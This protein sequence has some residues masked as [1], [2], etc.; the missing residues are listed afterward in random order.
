LRG[1]TASSRT[2][3]ALRRAGPRSGLDRGESGFR[4]TG[5]CPSAGG[6]AVPELSKTGLHSSPRRQVAVAP[7]GL[8]GPSVGFTPPALRL[9]GQPCGCPDSIR[10]N[11]GLGPSMDL[12][13]RAAWRLSGSA[14][15]P[16]R[17]TGD[18]N[19]LSARNAKRPFRG[20][21]ESGGEGGIRTP[22][23]L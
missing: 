11:P 15:L 1:T 7:Q 3:G 18:P 22:E 16:I 10:A 4:L 14:V 21:C 19:P 5:R 23:A 13:L 20:V 6:F 17:R 12:A 8:F 9:R 2:P